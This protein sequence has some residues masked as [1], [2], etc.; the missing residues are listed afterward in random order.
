MTGVSPPKLYLTF[1]LCALSQLAGG[2]CFPSVSFQ[3]SYLLSF[4][5]LCI[6]SVDPWLTF[7]LFVLFQLIWVNIS[8]LCVVSADDGC[9][10]FYISPLCAVSADLRLMFLLC[11]VTADLWLMFLLCVVTADLWR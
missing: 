7:Y 6:V 10:L 11:V 8:P 5:P 9:V 1:L 2:R 3:L 4:V